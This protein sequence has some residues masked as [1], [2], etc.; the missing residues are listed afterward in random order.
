[1][2]TKL[3]QYGITTLVVGIFSLVIMWMKDLFVQ[4]DSQEI[5]KIL[6]DSFFA[7]GIIAVCAGLLVVASNGGTFYIFSYG[8]S[9]FANLFKKDRTKMRYKTF[10]DYKKAMEGQEKKPY[11]FILIVGLVYVAISMI[12]MI[13][14]MNNQ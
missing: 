7:P 3:L 14:W 13:M 6:T 10:Y 12:F 11:G 9:S 8:L 2:K 5:L 1:M 4:T